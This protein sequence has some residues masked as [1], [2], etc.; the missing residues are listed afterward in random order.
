[1]E[2]VVSG[3]RQPLVCAGC[4]R[5]FEIGDRYIEDAPSGFMGSEDGERFDSLIA[6]V[7]GG[8]GE[9]I[10]Y[11]EACTIDTADGRYTFLTVGA[12]DD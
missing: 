9:T 3:T 8:S 2:A 5:K 4:S 6:S 1:M 11:C 12:D 7:L 10:R